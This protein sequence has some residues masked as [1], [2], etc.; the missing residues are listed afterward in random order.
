M[1]ADERAQQLGELMAAPTTLIAICDLCGGFAG[2]RLQPVVITLGLFLAK[3]TA[4]ERCLGRPVG[5]VLVPTHEE[6]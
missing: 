1:C 2:G 5:Y 4:C 3:L 6:N